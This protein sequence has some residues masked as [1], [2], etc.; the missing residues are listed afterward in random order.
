MPDSHFFPR[1]ISIRGG[2]FGIRSVGSIATSSEVN[3]VGD[4]NISAGGVD[5]AVFNATSGTNLVSYGLHYTSGTTA[6]FLLANPEVGRNVEFHALAAT[7]GTTYTV[8]VNTTD[9]LI[10]MSTG[11]FNARQ[12]AVNGGASVTLSGLTTGLYSI[13]ATR[14]NAVFSSST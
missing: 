10:S 9:T 3:A 7:T 6:T 4:V 14:G 1:G 13:S 12:F 8:V 2:A 11:G 5:L